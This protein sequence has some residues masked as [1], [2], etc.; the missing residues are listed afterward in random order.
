MQTRIMKVAGGA[1]KQCYYAQALVATGSLLILANE[2]T[3]AANEKK[4]LVPMLDKIKALP[5][6]LG[7]T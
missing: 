7:R 5:P 3:Q 4:Q 1:F 2:V 6:Q